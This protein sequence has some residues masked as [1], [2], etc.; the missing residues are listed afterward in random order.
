MAKIS[1]LVLKPE[2]D[3]QAKS[4]PAD[5]QG[6]QKF[7]GGSPIMTR[8]TD[9][10]VVVSNENATEEDP[11]NFTIFQRHNDHVHELGK[12]YS[13]AVFAAESEKGLTSLDKDQKQL[14]KNWFQFGR[15]KL[16][17]DE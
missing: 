9:G 15:D 7:I 16:L 10:I 3:F 5:P 11:L 2:R 13:D 6:I 8:L 4:V 12:L 14:V 1:A 17:L